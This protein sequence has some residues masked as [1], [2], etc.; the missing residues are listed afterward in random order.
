MNRS[1]APGSSS[2]SCFLGDLA[3]SA[4]PIDSFVHVYARIG[5]ALTAWSSVE[6]LVC[7]VFM[8]AI[9][10]RNHHA[11]QAAFFEVVSFDSKLSACDTAISIAL[12]DHQTHLAT[13]EAISRSLR[14]RKNIRNKLAHAQVL[15]HKDKP[16]ARLFPYYSITEHEIPEWNGGW[17]PQNIATFIQDFIDIRND[18][19]A[20]IVQ[21]RTDLDM[22]PTDW[23]PSA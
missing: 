6:D 20:F 9:S 15:A 16:G 17:T 4:T 12:K 14:K 5:E 11:A 13:W 18:L 2:I 3:M 10:P 22:W 23:R 7:T 21:L 19:T 1:A 8:C